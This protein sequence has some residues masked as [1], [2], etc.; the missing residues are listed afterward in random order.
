MAGGVDDKQPGDI[1]WGWEV[2]LALCY[3][4][5]QLIMR[6]ESSTNL[7]GNTSSFSFLDVGPSNFI[8][9][10]CLAGINVTQDTADWT[11]VLSMSFGKELMLVFENIRLL[12]FLSFFGQ[13]DLDFL[14]FS[15]FFLCIFIDVLLIH[16]QLFFDVLELLFGDS[17]L[18][19]ALLLLLSYL[20]TNLLDSFVFP[21][22]LFFPSLLL[23]FLLFF[24]LLLVLPLQPLLLLLECFLLFQLLFGQQG[25]SSYFASFFA[26]LVLALLL[27]FRFCLFCLFDLFLIAFLDCSK[28]G[29][30]FLLFLFFL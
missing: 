5:F 25:S 8:K 15:Y 19:C 12:L 24:Y 29:S 9:Q 1:D 30:F 21:L 6:E 14:F 22:L 11:S 23:F 7:L 3:F 2:I 17:L 20:G 26:F 27:G 4:I 10:S 13:H 16:F 28:S 18:V